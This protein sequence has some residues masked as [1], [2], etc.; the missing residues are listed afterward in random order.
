L[1]IPAELLSSEEGRE[2]V[3]AKLALKRVLNIVSDYH[4]TEGNAKPAFT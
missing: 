4:E 3:T 2:H 1:T